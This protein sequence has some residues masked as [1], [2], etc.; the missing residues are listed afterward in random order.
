[1]SKKRADERMAA[2]VARSAQ[3]YADH[4]DEPWVDREPELGLEDD[5]EGVYPDDIM[6]ADD[7]QRA[8]DMNEVLA[9][10]GSWRI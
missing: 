7:K 5:W 2:G 9:D 6:E 10:I 3:Y 8:E 4:Q 1:M